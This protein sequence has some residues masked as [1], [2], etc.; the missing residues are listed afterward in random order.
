MT[1]IF[2]I[3][4]TERK[5]LVTA[6][7]QIT[8]EDA[9]Y[10]GAPTFAYQ[11]G[12][13]TVTKDGDITLPD[14]AYCSVI[15]DALTTLAVKGFTA[16]SILFDDPSIQRTE[17]TKIT[18]EETGLT[19]SIPSNKV[20][21]ENLTNLLEAKGSLFKKALGVA[22]LPII[23][24]DETIS[25]PWFRDNLEPVEIDAYSYFIG[26]LCEMSRNQKRISNKEKNVEN[27]KYAF[28]CFLLRLGFIGDDHKKH[29][30]VLLRNLNGSSAFKGG[31]KNAISA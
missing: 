23:L 15:E 6:L 1:I 20:N 16:E 31:A 19:V 14:A 13:F 12:P 10:Q 7:T 22:N 30:K 28:R 29:R 11:I 3:P 26:A 5:S 25:F 27:E 18:A 4:K 9:K 8:S 2:S 17:T 24:N 21:M